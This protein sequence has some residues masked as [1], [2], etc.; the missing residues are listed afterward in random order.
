MFHGEYLVSFEAL[1]PQRPGEKVVVKLLADERDVTIRSGT[2]T[3]DHPAGGLLRVEVLGRKQGFALLVLP[4]PAQP[5]GE[6]ALVEDDLL[7]QETV[8]A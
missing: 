8:R 3:R 1:D 4:Q 2:P 7:A 6:R 5:V